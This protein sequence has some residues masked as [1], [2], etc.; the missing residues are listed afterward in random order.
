MRAANNARGTGN[1]IH[2]NI[3][4]FYGQKINELAV[5]TEADEGKLAVVFQ[6]LLFEPCQ[7]VVV[8]ALAMPQTASPVRKCD[9]GHDG[10][11]LFP[12]DALPCQQ[13]GCKGL[14]F[15][16][17]EGTMGKLRLE[18]FYGVE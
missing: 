5:K 6:S 7:I 14:W 1:I 17:A 13:G 3:M 8:I 18:L 12:L 10:T 9:A 15:A 4:A 11:Y 2:Q 16:H